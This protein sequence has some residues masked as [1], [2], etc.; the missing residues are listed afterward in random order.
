MPTTVSSIS[1]PNDAELR[2]F[3]VRVSAEG[4]RLYRDFA[5]RRTRDP[6]AV[7]VSEVMLQQTQTARVTRYWGAWME[8]FPTLDA[9]AGASMADVLSAWQGLGYNRRALALKR[10]A[11]ILSETCGGQLPRDE[12]A[13]RALPGI[14]PSTAAGMMAFAWGEPAA[15]LETNVRAVFLHEFFGEADDVSDREVLALVERCATLAPE[16]G[17]DAR[18]WNYALLDVGVELKRTLSNPSRRS[19]HHTRQSAFEGS[20]R[21]KRSALLQA[22]LADPGQSTEQL[23]EASGYPFE[24]CDDV[25]EELLSEGFLERA[26]DGAW[27][28]AP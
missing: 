16:E 7:L 6:Y 20:H 5:W 21:Q 14:G 11:E 15:Y 1:A 4:A 13:L 28:V 27:Q 12:K 8:R 24:V 19:K 26:R 23:A 3:I 9:L 22:V 17:I 18:S 2:R 25:L 10:A